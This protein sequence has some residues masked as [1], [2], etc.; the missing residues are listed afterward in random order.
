MF[1]GAIEEVAKFTRP[2][3]TIARNYKETTVTPGAATL[4][5]VNEEGVAVTCKHVIDLISNRQT[6]NQRY[7]KFKSRHRKK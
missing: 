2:V 5:F 1:V 6:I 3:L 7:E 4:F